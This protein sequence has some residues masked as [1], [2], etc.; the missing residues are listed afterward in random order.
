MNPRPALYRHPEAIAF[1]AAIRAEP[2]NDVHRLVFADWLDEFAGNDAPFLDHYAARAEG[3]RVACE[4]VGKSLARMNRRE[5]AWLKANWQ[6]LFP[7]LV[8]MNETNE[9]NYNHPNTPRGSLLLPS[10]INV[11]MTRTAIKI[12]GRKVPL[13]VTTG[14]Q[15]RYRSDSFFPLNNWTANIHV[16][17]GFV[18]KAEFWQRNCWEVLVPAL[19]QDDPMMDMPKPPGG[20][21]LVEQDR[22]W[23]EATDAIANEKQYRRPAPTSYMLPLSSNFIWSRPPEYDRPVFDGFNTR[24]EFTG[25]L[26]MEPVAFEELQRRLFVV[27]D[28]NETP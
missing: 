22:E 8:A 5:S 9:A 20:W 27:I 6:R 13:L 28:E 2:E 19:I 18:I 4:N 12:S 23:A 1:L 11:K 21:S 3:I 25:T 17:R 16:R 14:W 7:T 15:P 26:Q 10:D 24:A